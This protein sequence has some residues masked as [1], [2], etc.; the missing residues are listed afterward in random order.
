[1]GPGEVNLIMMATG[2]RTSGPRIAT[3]PVAPAM[4]IS[5]LQTS[6][7]ETSGVVLKIQQRFP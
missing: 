3:R 5:R 2:R 1:M 4:S 7:Q 6:C